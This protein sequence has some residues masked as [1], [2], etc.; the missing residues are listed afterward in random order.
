MQRSVIW[1]IV[2]LG[3]AGCDSRGALEDPDWV[4]DGG[5]TVDAELDGAVDAVV[6]DA[7]PMDA[8]IRDARPSDAEQP[9]A[10]EPDAAAPDAAEPDAAAPDAA[11]DADISDAALPDAQVDLGPDRGPPIACPDPRLAPVPTRIA[12]GRWMDLVAPDWPDA[13]YRW[14]ILR[15][16]ADSTALL[17]EIPA[18]IGALAPDDP[19]TPTAAFFPDIS[20][21]YFI[22]L[23]MTAPECRERRARF[24][25]RAI[26]LAA[27]HIELVWNTPGDARPGDGEGTDLDLHLLHPNA[28]SWNDPTWDCHYANPSPDWGQQGR[29]ADNPSLDVDDVDGEGPEH[30]T[31]GVV[32]PTAEIGG[33]YRLGVQYFS[34]SAFGR[35]EAVIRIFS[36]GALVRELRRDV[37]A[38]G[39]LW[40]V[41]DI[42][43]DPVR[44]D[45][46]DEISV[47]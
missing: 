37:I 44:I 15:A 27:L 12:P 22:E 2:F 3:M 42:H 33:P 8:R 29:G 41:V 7:G 39:D 36:E 43:T 17:G 25:V 6:P 32:Q 5:T 24:A 40:T 31:I 11:R 20:G 1:T 16:P 38:S 9:D 30:I 18:P 47:P 28:V 21:E 34:A 23:L 35:S 13:R 14:Q 10:A 4:P 45:V 26:N 46:I 19:D